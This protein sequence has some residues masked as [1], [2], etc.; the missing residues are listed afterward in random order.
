MV[1]C[2]YFIQVYFKF[3]SLRSYWDQS[4][5]KLYYRIEIKDLK[6]YFFT[7]K[8]KKHVLQSEDKNS[9]DLVCD[10]LWDPLSTDYLLVSRTLSGLF[11][12]FFAVKSS[13]VFFS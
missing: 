5:S 12:L 2:R 7:G 11:D 1:A 13:Y 8:I 10:L 4:W 6:Y 3:L 9:E